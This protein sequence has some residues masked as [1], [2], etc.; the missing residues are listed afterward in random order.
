MPFAASRGPSR[1]EIVTGAILSVGLNGAIRAPLP[2]GTAAIPLPVD[3]IG[4]G[5]HTVPGAA[6]PP[7]VPRAMILTAAAYRT[8]KGPETPFPPTTPWLI[9]KHGP[10]AFGAVL[11]AAILRQPPADSVEV[12][13]QPAVLPPARIA[14]TVSAAVNDMTIPDI[15][16]RHP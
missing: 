3:S 15:V 2:R 14:G 11:A 5:P 16:E 4:A 9:V 10:M 8:L 13:P 7:A 6:V 12:G 1:Q